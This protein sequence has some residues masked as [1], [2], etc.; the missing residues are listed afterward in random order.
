VGS[1][2]IGIAF[3]GR[4]IWAA[5]QQAN[6]VAQLQARNDILPR[7]I[8]VGRQPNGVFFDGSS[9]WVSNFN[10]GTVSKI[11]FMGRAAK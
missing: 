4:S 5:L 7:R 11:T 3:D 1:I 9:I 10:S 8:A 2:P 6:A